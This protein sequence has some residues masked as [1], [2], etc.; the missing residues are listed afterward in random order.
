VESVGFWEAAFLATE[1]A[2]PVDTQYVAI[3]CPSTSTTI[4]MNDGGS[5]STQTCSA[6]GNTPG[7]AYF[8]STTDGTNINA[9][10]TISSDQPIY[11]YYE[12]ASN[13]DEHNLLGNVS[14]GPAPVA[15]VSVP[16]VVGSAQAT[17]ES[18]IAAAG[19][20]VG[21]ITT[22]NSTT[23]AAAGSF[24]RSGYCECSG[25]RWAFTSCG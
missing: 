10:A 19:L 2:I 6:S 12:E 5:I 20:T 25:C 14:F 4:T 24:L 3:A 7:K 11:L 22:A 16:S 13:S 9:G 17:A 15:D 21:T 18:D 8:G 1:Y 23:V